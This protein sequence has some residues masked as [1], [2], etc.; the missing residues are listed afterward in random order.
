MLAVFAFVFLK[1]RPS[2]REWVGILM[3]GGG[4]LVL[5]IKR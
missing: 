1:E 4:V 2:G 5:A 3:V